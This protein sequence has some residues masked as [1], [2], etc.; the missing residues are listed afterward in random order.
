VIH[1]HVLIALPFSVYDYKV[2]PFSGAKVIEDSTNVASY[3]Y[4]S[5]SKELVSYDTPNIV[6]TKV[7]YINSNGMAVSSC[8]LAYDGQN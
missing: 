3:S 5:A 1:N 2:L 6:K 8:R 7:Q 4:D